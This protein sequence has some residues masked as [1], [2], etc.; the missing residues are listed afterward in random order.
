LH[1]IQHTLLYGVKATDTVTF[2]GVM[3]V[4]GMVAAAA[5]LLPA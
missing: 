4:V 3:G 1:T 5:S 2:G